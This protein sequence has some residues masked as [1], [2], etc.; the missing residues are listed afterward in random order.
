MNS[1]CSTEYDYELSENFSSYRKKYVQ[2]IAQISIEDPIYEVDN[3]SNENF[4]LNKES[5]DHS[6]KS[7]YA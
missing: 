2:N 7:K 4:C 3:E 1:E 5:D 6:F